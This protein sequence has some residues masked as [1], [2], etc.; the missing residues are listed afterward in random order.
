VKFLLNFLPVSCIGEEAARNS[1]YEDPDAALL[2]YFIAELEKGVVIYL[3][4]D[5]KIQARMRI[6]A[7]S[8]TERNELLDRIATRRYNKAVRVVIEQNFKRIQDEVKGII[9]RECRQSQQIT[10]AKPQSPDPRMVDA[11]AD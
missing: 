8:S 3:P 5:M 2:D 9:D 11:F 6:D 7:L 1:V 10:I 4:E